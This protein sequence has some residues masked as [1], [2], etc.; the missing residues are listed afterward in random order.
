MWIETGYIVAIAKP[1][2][3]SALRA[4]KRVRTMYHKSWMRKRAWMV[5]DSPYVEEG[6]T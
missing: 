3:S 4:Q 5:T 1:L 2:S 6:R